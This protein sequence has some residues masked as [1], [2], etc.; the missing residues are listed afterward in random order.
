MLWLP[1]VVLAPYAALEGRIE[2]LH[3]MKIGSRGDIYKK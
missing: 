1:F 2:I 3:I